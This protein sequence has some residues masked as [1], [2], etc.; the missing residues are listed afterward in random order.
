M[1]THNYHS[2][3]LSVELWRLAYYSTWLLAVYFIT[4]TYHF[5]LD[6]PYARLPQL[7]TGLVWIC[8]CSEKEVVK[9]HHLGNLHILILS[10]PVSYLSTLTEADS[11]PVYGIISRSPIDR[12]QVA[13]D[14]AIGTSRFLDCSLNLFWSNSSTVDWAV[15]KSLWSFERSNPS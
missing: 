10:I 5:H 4:Q 15:W 14:S 2:F 11:L 7:R 13:S 1:P 12:I 6:V 3:G 8:F 9:A